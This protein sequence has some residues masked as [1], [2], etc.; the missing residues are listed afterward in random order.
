MGGISRDD[1]EGEFRSSPKEG[2][3]ALHIF[4]SDEIAGYIKCAGLGAL[5]VNDIADIYQDVMLDMILASQKP[6]FDPKEP[7]RLVYR[8]AYTNTKDFLRKRGIR[9][10]AN[11]DDCLE[12]L[13]KDLKGSSVQLRWKYMTPDQQ[14]AFNS[15]LFDVIC[16]LPEMQKVTALVFITR[17]KETRDTD[18]FAEV[19][20][21]VREF[22][23]HDMTAAAAKGNWYR[24]R[25][26]IAEKMIQRGF[27]VYTTE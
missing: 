1:L 25:P 6:G 11:L 8:I 4:F 9:C 24:A 23:G 2:M 12:H 15:A 17:Y 21:G 18:L 26:T 16:E 19:A 13:A 20:T 5:D 14:E 22:S 27:D 3:E 10:A 7:M